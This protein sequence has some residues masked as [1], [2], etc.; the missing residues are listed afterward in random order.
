MAD[1]Q[2][3]LDS[4]ADARRTWDELVTVQPDIKVGSRHLM[5][6]D[7]VELERLLGHDLSLWDP[8]RGAAAGRESA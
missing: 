5:K 3:L 4:F 6:S 8:E 7:L 1:H 2:T